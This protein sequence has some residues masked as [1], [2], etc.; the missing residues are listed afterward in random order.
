MRTGTAIVE[1][2]AERFVL[3]IWR[4]IF[5]KANEEKSGDQLRVWRAVG[6]GRVAAK[7][8]WPI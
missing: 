1:T 3:L 4:E 7:R 8:S 2:M 6:I 5:A